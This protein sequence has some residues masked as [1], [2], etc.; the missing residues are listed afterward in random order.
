MRE[1]KLNPGEAFHI[2]GRRV[3]PG[4]GDGWT[5]FGPDSSLQKADT[6]V[7]V[8]WS[9]SSDYRTIQ[10]VG[11]SPF[12]PVGMEVSV[13]DGSECTALQKVEDEIRRFETIFLEEGATE[14]WLI[15]WGERAIA[16]RQDDGSFY[17]FSIFVMLGMK[18][19]A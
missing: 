13:Q 3:L 5:S 19:R 15:H 4:M 1:I 2:R 11:D 9:M 18:G 7:E 6:E 17:S 14:V 8:G 10:P 12:L 16:F